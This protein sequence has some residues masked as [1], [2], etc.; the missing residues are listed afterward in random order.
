MRLPI[1]GISRMR[2]N[3]S[4]TLRPSFS[5]HAAHLPH[6]L[7]HG[8]GSSIKADIRSRPRKQI[9][10][11]QDHSPRC[12]LQPVLLLVSQCTV[13]ASYRPSLYSVLVLQVPFF[14][15]SRVTPSCWYF[16]KDVRC[17]SVAERCRPWACTVG[18]LRKFSMSILLFQFYIYVHLGFLT[19]FAT[20]VTKFWIYSMAPVIIVLCRGDDVTSSN[21]QRRWYSNSTSFRFS[22]TAVLTTECRIGFS[23]LCVLEITFWTSEVIKA[24]TTTSRNRR[25]PTIA[26]LNNAWL[27]STTYSA[28]NG[29]SSLAGSFSDTTCTARAP[30]TSFRSVDARTASTVIAL[31]ACR[32]L[33]RVVARIM[34]SG[35]GTPNVFT[36]CSIGLV[37]SYLCCVRKGIVWSLK[38]NSKRTVPT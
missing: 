31:P 8:T 26:S 17:N 37:R 19:T 3:P 9:G 28:H 25:R 36:G 23:R 21:L 32:P 15:T 27:R 29:R 5:C 18:G 6:R 24:T 14:R 38:M 13:L 1:L 20:S 22:S 2:Y 34:R 12:L 33:T 30:R 11:W 35:S 4:C 7:H 16:R 10:Y